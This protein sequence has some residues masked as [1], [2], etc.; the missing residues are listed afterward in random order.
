MTEGPSTAPPW[1]SRAT[2]RLAHAARNQIRYQRLLNFGLLPRIQ[3][4]RQGEAVPAVGRQTG[5]LLAPDP[6]AVPAVGWEL[7]AR[8]YDQMIKY[9]TAMRTRT[10]STE[11]ISRPSPQRRTPHLRGSLEVGRVQKTVFVAY[12][13]RLR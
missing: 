6:G 8:Q 10:V 13:L 7:I 3:A 5:R 11:A 12:Y 2:R 4:D 9:A 1:T